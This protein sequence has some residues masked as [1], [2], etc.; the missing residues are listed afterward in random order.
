MNRCLSRAGIYFVLFLVNLILCSCAGKVQSDVFDVN[1]KISLCDCG[2][3]S[4]RLTLE[5]DE[6]G[7]IETVTDT[8]GNYSFKNVW[9]GT[10]I[11]TPV[12]EGYTFF[13]ATREITVSDSKIELMDFNT[14][15]SWDVSLGESD[16]NG[17]AFSVVNT[18]D[19]GFLI[20]G[21]KDV[22]TTGMENLD[23]WIMKIDQYGAM[24]WENTYGDQSYPDIAY[25]AIID[26]DGNIVIGGYSDSVDAGAITVMKLVAD[27]TAGNS[28][29]L[30]G[31][32]SKFYGTT[33]LPERPAFIIQTNDNGYYTAGYSGGT[34]GN[35][36]D[37]YGV[38]ID[39][40]GDQK[41]LFSYGDSD[42]EKAFAADNIIRDPYY[43]GGVIV[44]GER[45]G[46]DDSTRAF[47]LKRDGILF[48]SGWSKFYTAKDPVT[49]TD[50]FAVTFSSVKETAD[51]GYICAGTVRKFNLSTRDLYIVKTDRDGNEEWS[52][53]IDGGADDC[54]ST[55]VLTTDGGYAAG[56]TSMSLTGDGYNYRLVKLNSSGEIEWQRVYDSGDGSDDYLRGLTQTYDGGFLLCGVRLSNMGK[57]QIYIIKT[58]RSGDLPLKGEK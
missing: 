51:S 41:V 27:G 33:L 1:G 18:P 24:V 34:T 32:W 16:K 44:A 29:K 31:G 6:Y 12:K 4:V 55:V 2:N 58:D 14:I 38:K 50:S 36:E 25:G 57:K 15:V 30:T 3:N 47:L 28:W 49:L 13:P 53:I 45:K 19:C 8:D 26:N 40:S 7:V 56:S 35:L 23:M 46:S 42:S 39:Y 52:R 17:E 5:N 37:V 54:D 43:F 11:I 22:S 20:A 10:Y 21:Y 48:S 9:K